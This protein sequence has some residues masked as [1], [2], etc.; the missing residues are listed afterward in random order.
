MNNR[1]YSIH[2]AYLINYLFFRQIKNNFCLHKC[3]SQKFEK[4]KFV[5]IFNHFSVKDLILAK[6]YFKKKEKKQIKIFSEI[7]QYACD[8]F[9]DIRFTLEKL[10][11]WNKQSRKLFLCL[12]PSTVFYKKLDYI[13]WKSE[14]KKSSLRKIE[15]AFI[16]AYVYIEQIC[17]Q[18]NLM[19][20]VSFLKRA[21]IYLFP[22]IDKERKNRKKRAENVL[23]LE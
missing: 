14:K 10:N 11:T 3:R 13:F 5:P 4:K 1:V 17:S 12:F 22:I 7:L 9:E 18:W 20:F 6:S 16:T 23:F 19:C 21:E 8:W 15:V 2:L